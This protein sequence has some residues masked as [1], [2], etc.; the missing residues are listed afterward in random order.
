MKKSLLVLSIILAVVLLGFGLAGCGTY[1]SNG[2]NTAGYLSNQ[3]TGI[4]VT[5]VGKVTVVPDT[6]VLDLGVQVQAAS[7]VDAQTQATQAMTVILTVMKKYN[8][9]DKDISTQNYSIYPVY[10]YSK[11]TQTITGYSVSNK[12]SVKIRTLSDTG[13]ILAEAATAGGNATTVNSLNFIVD[14]PTQDENSARTLAVADAQNKAE[15]LAHQT[16]VKLGKVSYVNESGG[17]TPPTPILFAATA[18]A[19]VAPVPVSP[20]TIDVEIDIQVVYNI[21]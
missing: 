15:Q 1:S 5:G 20:G 12:L 8:I 21:S 9:A 2:T 10:S 7:V 18:G 6:A 19:A 16:G 3:D 11:G 14:D 17:Y 4:W 13:N